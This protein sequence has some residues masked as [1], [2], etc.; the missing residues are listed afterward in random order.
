MFIE[1]RKRIAE[2]N[3]RYELGLETYTLGINEFSDMLPSE[4]LDTMTGLNASMFK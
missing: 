4:F 1:N 3:A 2:H